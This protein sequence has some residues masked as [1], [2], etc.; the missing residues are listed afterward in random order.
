MDNAK[1]IA[2]IEAAGPL[3]DGILSI[4]GIEDS[5]AQWVIRFETFDIIVDNIP[6]FGKLVFSIVIDGPPAETEA[7]AHRAMLA[8]NGLWRET[9]GARIALAGNDGAIE[10]SIDIASDLATAAVVAKTAAGLGEFAAAWSLILRGEVKIDQPDA[11]DSHTMI[12]A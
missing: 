10:I 4:V 6:E 9:G 8:Q 5:E 1:A 2:I 12:R 11:V 7:A 3:D